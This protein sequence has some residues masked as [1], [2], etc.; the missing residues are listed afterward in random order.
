MV[1]GVTVGV[2]GPKTPLSNYPASLRISTGRKRSAIKPYLSDYVETFDP[3]MLAKGQRRLPG[4][5]E[6]VNAHKGDGILLNSDLGPEKDPAPERRALLLEPTLRR[7]PRSS[8]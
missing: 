3:Q 1:G 4:F 2:F 5:D 6:K 8:P 7:S